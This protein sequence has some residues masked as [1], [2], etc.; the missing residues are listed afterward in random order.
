MSDPTTYEEF[1]PYYVRAHSQ[2]VTRVLH[3]IGS[4]A[5]LLAV[6][7]A[8]L[9][10][11]KKFLLAA[12]V[13]GYGPAWFSHFVIEGNKP[14]TFGH[15]LWS[16]RGDFEMISRMLAGTMDAEVERCAAMQGAPAEAPAAVTNGH[17]SG[18]TNGQ[19]TAPATAPT[20]PDRTLH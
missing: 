8:V 7:A 9:T 16:L 17:A 10:G 11:K 3:A 19:G 4:S 15:P 6:G 2:K 5:A 1:W 20:T 18:P 12:P 14:A 13:L